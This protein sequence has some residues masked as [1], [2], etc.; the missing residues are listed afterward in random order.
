MDTSSLKPEA[1]LERA[2]QGAHETVDRLAEAAT[3]A[4]EQISAAVDDLGSAMNAQADEALALQQQW[5]GALRDAV[6]EHP[7]A[8][9]L[10]AA[11]VGVLLGNTTAPA[12]RGPWVM[13]RSPSS[14][15]APSP[16]SC[17]DCSRIARDS[18]PCS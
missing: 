6:R 18:A 16:I 7:I 10:T 17:G 12:V 4:V 14:Q 8:A 13:R 3:P 2:V 9:V 5:T 1:L 15:P 11:A